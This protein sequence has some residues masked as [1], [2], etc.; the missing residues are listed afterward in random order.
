MLYLTIAMRF[1]GG[2][3]ILHMEPKSGWKTKEIA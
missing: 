2:E 3:I 1:L